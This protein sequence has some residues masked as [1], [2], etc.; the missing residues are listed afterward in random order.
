MRDLEGE[1]IFCMNMRENIEKVRKGSFS[2]FSPFF[3]GKWLKTEKSLG[4]LKARETRWTKWSTGSRKFR[5]KARKPTPA[6]LFLWLLSCSRPASQ[7][8][9]QSASQPT[10]QPAL[11]T[12]HYCSIVNYLT[13][14]WSNY[15][16]VN[17][18]HLTRLSAYTYIT[19][20]ADILQ[21]CKPLFVNENPLNMSG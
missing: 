2:L 11:M 3:I 5:N 21:T 1:A 4:I 20:L 13:G 16:L 15:N 18:S 6:I 10:L 12:M 9:S 17:R 19:L 8:A 7:P 14:L